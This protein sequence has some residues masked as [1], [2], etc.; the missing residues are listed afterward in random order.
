MERVG[1]SSFTS[2][3]EGVCVSD[4]AGSLLACASTGI[5]SFVCACSFV[6]WFCCKLVWLDGGS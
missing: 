2:A 5:T 3:D 6:F 1:V 4:V